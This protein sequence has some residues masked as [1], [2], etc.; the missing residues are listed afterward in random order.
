MGAISLQA[1][2]GAIPC[3]TGTSMTFIQIS[4]QIVSLNFISLVHCTPKK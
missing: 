1:N 4:N 3:K 2:M